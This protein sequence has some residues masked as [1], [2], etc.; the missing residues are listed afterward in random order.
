MLTLILHRKEVH[1][2]EL[3]DATAENSSAG[4]F[5]VLTPYLFSP[6]DVMIVSERYPIRRKTLWEKTRIGYKLR[7]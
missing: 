1:L 4:F 7:E 2:S 6:D 5:L 3:F